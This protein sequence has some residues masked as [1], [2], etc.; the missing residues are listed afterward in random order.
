M[1]N[2]WVVRG[3]KNINYTG[4]RIHQNMIENI[5]NKITEEFGEIRPEAIQD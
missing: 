2:G 5:F 3:V 1:A 4:V